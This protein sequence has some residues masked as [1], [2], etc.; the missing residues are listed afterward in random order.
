MPSK[1]ALSALKTAVRATETIPTVL[2]KDFNTLE[3]PVIVHP[4]PCCLLITASPSD[5]FFQEHSLTYSLIHHILLKL[6]HGRKGPFITQLRQ[7][8]VHYTHHHT[9]P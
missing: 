8:P 7:H 6:C 1:A 9:S 3:I 2:H 5:L 4:S